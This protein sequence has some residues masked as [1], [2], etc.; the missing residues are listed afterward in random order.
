MIALTSA[1]IARIRAA[2]DGASGI[3]RTVLLVAF[4]AGGPIT[5]L[6][7]C[8]AWSAWERRAAS[9]TV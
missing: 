2:I 9:E 1:G 5:T 7:I 4:F 8:L 6:L 3:K